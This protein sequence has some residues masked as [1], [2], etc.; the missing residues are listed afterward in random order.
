MEKITLPN[1]ELVMR[2]ADVEITHR[3]T[4]MTTT[5][6]PAQLDRWALRWLR[7][8]LSTPSAPVVA[9]RSAA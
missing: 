2:G 7:E 3:R 6:S 4:G 8:E 1:V 5:V 9:E